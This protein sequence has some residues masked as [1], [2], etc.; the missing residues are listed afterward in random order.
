MTMYIRLMAWWPGH[1]WVWAKHIPIQDLWADMHLE[2]FT[3][4]AEPRGHSW[5]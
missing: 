2:L 3:I 4:S 5:S 1:L